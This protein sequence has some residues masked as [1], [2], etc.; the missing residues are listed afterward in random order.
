MV[1]SLFT[2]LVVLGWRPAAV[3]YLQLANEQIINKQQ[4]S[5]SYAFSE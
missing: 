3:I 1:E 2:N 5:I 4:P